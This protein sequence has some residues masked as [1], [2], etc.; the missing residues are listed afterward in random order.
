MFVALIFSTTNEGL[1]PHEYLLL[2]GLHPLD[3]ND[4]SQLIHTIGFDAQLH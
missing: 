4:R 1:P 2:W 3:T